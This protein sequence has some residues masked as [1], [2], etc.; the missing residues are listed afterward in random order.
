MTKK[1]YWV[2]WYIADQPRF[3]NLLFVNVIQ[4]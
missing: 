1:D 3:N 2:G 4:G